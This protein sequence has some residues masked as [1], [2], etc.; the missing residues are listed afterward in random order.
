MRLDRVTRNRQS[1]LEQEAALSVPDR[2][3]ALRASDLLQKA[4]QA[5]ITADEHYRDWL[6]ARHG[7]RGD[8]KSPDLAAAKASDSR[9]TRLKRAFVAVFDPLARRFRQR[10]WTVGEF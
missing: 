7:C 1:L 4:T 2:A 9:A 10:V 3:P 5:S 6:L 8:A